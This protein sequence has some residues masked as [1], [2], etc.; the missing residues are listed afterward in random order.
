MKK[1]IYFLLAIIFAI[2]LMLY[3]RNTQ[4]TIKIGAILPL[5]GTQASAGEGM[6]NALNMALQN[7]KGRKFNYEL[8]IED[9]AF[10]PKTSISAANKLINI[11]HVSAIIDAYAPIGLAIS[12]ITEKNKVVHINIAFDPKIAQGDYNFI[13]FSTPENAAQ[14]FL[15]EMNKRGLKTMSIFKVNN[16]GILSVDKAFNDLASRN[17]VKILSDETFQPEE[18]DFHS[19]IAK[20][21]KERAD[22]Y[23]LLALSPG[24]EILTKQLYEQNIHNI[25]S[26][27]YL[28]LAK[29]K[30][31]FEGLW[32]IGFASTSK[33]FEAEYKSKYNRDIT[34][35]VP[36]VYD[37]FNLIVR[38]AETFDGSNLPSNEYLMNEL[39]KTYSFDGVIGHLKMN[40]EGIIDTPLITKIVRDGKLVIY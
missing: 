30:S 16:Q 1:I 19:I 7:Q 27:I 5:S 21:T 25:S 23:V 17:G 14:K 22:I 6:R 32:T 38:S 39:K 40:P 20:G 29:D 26:T 3:G 12:P 18:R 33:E 36:N 10:D 28:E 37:A 8:V 31:L 4:K 15:D 9:G 13:L 24:L 2:V 34:F 11:D 35:G